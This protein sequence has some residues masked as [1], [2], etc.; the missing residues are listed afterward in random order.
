MTNEVEVMVDIEVTN[1]EKQAIYQRL[2]KR[3]LIRRET[4]LPPLEIKASY[5][6][7]VQNLEDQRYHA[8][9]EPHLAAAYER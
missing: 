2:L 5:A 1:E 4:G 9:I 6:R 8:A 7:Q 3:N